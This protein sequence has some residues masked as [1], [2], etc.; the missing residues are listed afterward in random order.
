MGRSG[1][2]LQVREGVSRSSNPGAGTPFDATA[3][4]ARSWAHSHCSAT[5]SNDFLSMVS[6]L[7]RSR[8]PDLGWTIELRPPL[9]FSHLFLSIAIIEAGSAGRYDAVAYRLG[10]VKDWLGSIGVKGF[11]AGVVDCELDSVDARLGERAMPI[12]TSSDGG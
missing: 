7:V 8:L 1:W 11:N 5:L 3:P 6:I 12:W 9:T 4:S 10:F 2:S